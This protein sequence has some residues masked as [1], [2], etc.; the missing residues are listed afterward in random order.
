M[1]KEQ[2]EEERVKQLEQQVYEL[3]KQVGWAC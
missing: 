1:E 2:S 3:E